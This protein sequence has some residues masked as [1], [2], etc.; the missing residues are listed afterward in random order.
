MVDINKVYLVPLSKEGESEDIEYY[1]PCK[2]E[3]FGN[4][5][6]NVRVVALEDGYRV[7]RFV[8]EYFDWLIRTQYTFIIEKINHPI[9]IWVD[10]ERPVPDGEFW[11]RCRT[12]NAT[13][14]LI[15]AS[16]LAENEIEIIDLDHDAGVFAC[17]GGDY[18][19]I[20]DWLEETG[21]NYPI[22]I[23]SMNPVGVNNMRAI[24]RKNGW[25]ELFQ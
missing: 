19:K 5:K 21:R 11:I 1:V 22:R 6:Q 18:I 7:K 16:E 23:H 20:L 17:Q 13:K 2:L 4:K 25:R 3:E 10:D 9:R 12:V 14:K 8:T 15:V 24:I